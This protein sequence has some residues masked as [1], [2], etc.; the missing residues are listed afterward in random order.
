M[1]TAQKAGLAAIRAE[2]F[3]VARLIDE[4]LGIGCE[5]YELVVS[6]AAEHGS[7][8]P[9][10]LGAIEIACARWSNLSPSTECSPDIVAL[11]ND[12]RRL[13]AWIEGKL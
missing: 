13:R 9:G 7:V 11:R 3:R 6:G 8:L 2:A 4:E 10:D 5:V 1:N 12:C